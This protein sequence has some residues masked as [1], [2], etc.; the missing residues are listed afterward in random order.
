[1]QGGG[2]WRGPHGLRKWFHPKGNTIGLKDTHLP[3]K[4]V[5]E[6]SRT[7]REALLESLQRA[8]CDCG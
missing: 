1:M 2:E 4:V 6:L 7:H 5:H 8:S 3:S